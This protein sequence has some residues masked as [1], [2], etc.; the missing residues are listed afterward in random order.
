[1]TGATF[2]RDIFT[3][4]T[5]DPIDKLLEGSTCECCGHFDKAYKRQISG[6]MCRDL[7]ALYKRDKFFMEKLPT[8]YSGY[9]HFDKFITGQAGD[10]AKMR[11][12]GLIEAK[13]ETREDGSDRNGYWKITNTGKLFVENKIHLVKYAII[14]QGK[15]KDF[16]GQLQSII[17]RLGTKFNYNELMGL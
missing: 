10:F 3:Q 5:E 1:M 16:Y 14:Y 13:E 8:D 6:K 17:T 7:I 11:Y 12:W 9:H 2:T 4:T 15:L